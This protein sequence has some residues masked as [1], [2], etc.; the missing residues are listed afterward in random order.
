MPRLEMSKEVMMC[1]GLGQSMGSGQETTA[2]QEKGAGALAF[3][4]YMLKM[5]CFAP[6]VRRSS[7]GP[8]SRNDRFWGGYT[9]T[10]LTE[11]RSRRR[12]GG[13]GPWGWPKVNKSLAGRWT[14]SSGAQKSSWGHG[15]TGEP[16][17]A[18][19]TTQGV[20][21]VRRKE[22]QLKNSGAHGQARHRRRERGLDASR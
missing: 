15:C 9:A 18:G 12:E 8:L 3:G 10:R 4:L 5:E 7:G 2:E 19:V 14:P 20:G 17:G 6:K 22:G 11:A 16:E 13:G 1:T 21:R